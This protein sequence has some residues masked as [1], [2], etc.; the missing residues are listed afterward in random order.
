MH[1]L[2][3]STF[4]VATVPNSSRR[5]PVVASTSSPSP[6]GTKYFIIRSN[7]QE[8]IEISVREGA[9]STTRFNEQ[10]SQIG[11]INKIS[12]ELNK[13]S[14][15]NLHLSPFTSASPLPVLEAQ[16]CIPQLSRSTAHVLGQ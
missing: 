14:H 2:T 1:H 3:I 16:R 8:N 11:C 4:Q 7:C 6:Q 12:V 13:I 15:F 10:V 5:E 9:W